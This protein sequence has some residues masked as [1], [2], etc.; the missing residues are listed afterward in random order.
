MPRLVIGS[1]FIPW[2]NTMVVWN[3]D[4]VTMF[5]CITIMI[6]LYLRGGE[7]ESFLT[8]ANIEAKWRTEKEAQL[9]PLEKVPAQVNRLPGERLAH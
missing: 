8:K 9:L 1:M 3:R 5:I 4:S 7:P 6:L 2:K